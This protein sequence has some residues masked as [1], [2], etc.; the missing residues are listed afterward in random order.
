MKRLRT[1]QQVEALRDAGMTK[2][3]A[4]LAIADVGHASAASIWNWFSL[5]DGVNVVDRLAY[6]V[7][8]Y[9]SGGKPAEIDAEIYAV[10]AADY[11]RPECLS[12]AECFRRGAELARARK[13]KLPHSR[14]LWRRLNRELGP[15]AI[16][17]M[18]G[19]GMPIWLLALP[20]VND[21]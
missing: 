21:R 14:T 3:E 9:R 4:V 12:W 6:L 20:A 17:R 15:R 8:T 11:L 19:E 2:S 7:P 18:R 10:I 1:L 16:S 5:V 13:I